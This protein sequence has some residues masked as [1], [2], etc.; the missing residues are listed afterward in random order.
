MYITSGIR[1]IQYDQEHIL[2]SEVQHQRG[3]R[4]AGQERLQQQPKHHRKAQISRSE[5]QILIPRS[6]VQLDEP[7]QGR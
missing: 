6:V 5:T 7:T 4:L 3:R 1:V 2:W